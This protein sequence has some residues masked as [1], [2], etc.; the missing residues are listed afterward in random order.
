MAKKTQH[1]HIVECAFCDNVADSEEHYLGQWLDKIFV[2]SHSDR[3]YKDLF[4]HRSGPLQPIVEASRK[5]K[6]RNGNL[7]TLR[8]KI[9]CQKCNNGWMSEIQERASAHLRRLIANEDHVV[10]KSAM[11]DVGKWATMVTM[12]F[13]FDD[14]AYM[15]TPKS[16]RIY[17]KE[18]RRT[19][20]DWCIW[21][22]RHSGE[23]WVTRIVHTGH[24]THPIGDR[25][26]GT[27]PVTF[28]NTMI[29]LGFMD[30]Y[31]TSTTLPNVFDQSAARAYELGHFVFDSVPIFPIV[32]SEI[33]WRQLLLKGDQEMDRNYHFFAEQAQHNNMSN[34][35]VLAAYSS[36]PP[37]A[38]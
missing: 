18:H 24:R 31:V 7:T 10:N 6:V 2:R 33:S 5:R 26:P 22:G 34:P 11:E 38:D 36:T 3:H 14:P 23:Q 20:P 9:V 35:A 13:E 29:A 4:N 16:Q 8:K 21:L 30:I 19:P 28:Q 32:P 17:F 12:T 15:A 1:R 37:T 27:L 25:P